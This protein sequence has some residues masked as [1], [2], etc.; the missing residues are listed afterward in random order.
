MC[1]STATQGGS[2]ATETSPQPVF[3]ARFRRHE[4][5]LFCGGRRASR[6]GEHIRRASDLHSCSLPS[7]TLRSGAIRSRV[8][9]VES[10]SRRRV[11]FSK[12]IG[13]TTRPVS[14]RRPKLYD[15]AAHQK[16][17]SEFGG[18]R[19]RYRGGDGN[20]RRDR[21][22][23]LPEK[24][25]LREGNRRFVR[26]VVSLR[27]FAQRHEWEG[28]R[29]QLRRLLRA[30]RARRRAYRV[31]SDFWRAGGEARRPRASA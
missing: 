20:S 26:V 21:G 1:G 7:E 8:S 27:P 13:E 23:T 4:E 30:F 9:E 24:F 31:V 6:W 18:G 22:G 29:G 17:P 12:R 3:R 28:P 19:W 25:S 15:G 16:G 11:F 14:H 2:T 10:T 5:W